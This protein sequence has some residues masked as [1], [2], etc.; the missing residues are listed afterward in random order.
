M[1]Y[2]MLW[3]YFYIVSIGLIAVYAFYDCSQ[4]V[5]WN[6]FDCSLFI[7][8]TIIRPTLI[9]QIYFYTSSSCFL[10]GILLRVIGSY[11]DIAYFLEFYLERPGIFLSESIK[12]FLLKKMT[13]CDSE[14]S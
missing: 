12:K 10:S 8:H 11:S 14:L 3:K 4:F 5:E 7:D 2:G 1:M 9:I 6:G 13:Y